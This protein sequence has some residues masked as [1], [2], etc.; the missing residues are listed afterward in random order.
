MWRNKP[1]IETL[2]LDNLF[3]NL[4]DYKSEVKGTS[5]STTNSHNVAF[6]SS[7]STSD[8]T[9]AVNIAQGVNT[10]S[11]QGDADSSTTVENLSDDVIY[12]FFASQPIIPQLDNE[13]LLQIH[14]DDL[15][16]MDLR[17]NIAMLTMKARRFL[18][19]TGRKLDMAN[20]E[21][22]RF[23]KSKVECFNCHKRG[24]FARECRAPRNQ[25]S[26]NK[27]PTR[28]TLPVEET[29]SNA[30]VSQCDSFGYDWCDQVEEDLKNKGVIDSGCSR[31]MTGNKSYLT[32]Y[33][34]I[35]RG[36][37]A[38]GDFLLIDE[39]HVLLKVPRKDNMYSVDLK[40]VVPQGGTK[41][42]TDAREKKDAEDPGN[43][44]GNPTEGESI[45]LPNDPNMPELEDIVYSDDDE[46]DVGQRLKR[47]SMF[48]N[49]QDLKIQTSLTEFTSRK[50]SLWFDIKALELEGLRWYSD[51]TG[52]QVKQ[53]EDEIFISQDKYVTEI[54][55]K[56][57]FSDIKTAS[58]PMETHKPLLKDA[59][60][61]DINEH[62]YRS[63][64]GLLMY[65][66][67][68]RPDIMFVVCV[69]ARFQVNP[70]VSQ[71]HAVKRIF[72]Y[73]KGQPKLGLW[74][75]KDSPFDLVAYTDW[76]M[77][78][79]T[80]DRKSTTEGC[81]FLGCR[82]IS[83]QCKKQ[84]VVC[85]IPHK[86]LIYVASFMCVAKWL[87]IQIN[88]GLWKGIRVNAGDSKLMLLGINLLLLEKVNAAR[89]NLLL[90]VL[91]ALVD[92]KKVIITETSVRRDLQLKDVE[93]IECLPNA[94]IFEQLALM[95]YEK[96]SQK[97]TFY[98]AFFSPQWKFLIHTILQC[99]SA[100]STAWNEFSNTM[101]SAIICLATTENSNSSMYIFWQS[102]VKIGS[103]ML[104]DPHHTPI[105]QPSTSQPQK[106]QSRRKQI[107]D[108][109]I[110][111]SSGP[112]EPIADE[113]ANEENVPTQSNDPPLSRVNTIRSG[114]D[115]LT[116]KELMDLCTKLSDSVLDLETTK[117]AQAKEITSLKK[118][119]KNLERKRKSKTPG[120]KRLFK[121]GRS[122]QVV[123]SEDEG[124]GDQG[125]HLRG[126]VVSFEELGVRLPR[127][128][129][130][131]V[132]SASG[133]SSLQ[134]GDGGACV[135]AR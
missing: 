97:H 116:L 125:Y 104:H 78:G 133:G 130:E 115:R 113:T 48:V 68:S 32:D 8:A 103:T 98:K 128:D 82:L 134:E 2:S 21:R 49:H 66:T 55:K 51:S 24:H 37:V 56:F 28:R 96:P 101:A 59:D 23:D 57:G 69:C 110:P 92:R 25:D 76:T 3:N 50:G 71:L 74:Y 90:L 80:L 89:H 1:E 99:L 107:K 64:I 27:E 54:L 77:Q 108:T 39:R 41:D 118:R 13:Y 127:G 123:S 129:E 117:T 38:F 94:D 9:R 46:C 121:I 135:A 35:N 29:T 91:Q 102:L 60:G 122:V 126:H 93:G 65:L 43:E 124:L 75:P 18:K 44:S 63:M 12:S 70:K 45:E 114:E 95:R 14:P 4:K 26:R 34:E 42:V 6:L 16:E 5:S 53:K 36:F 106:K 15:E 84:T 73:L 40:N 10:A 83:W 86:K 61:E 105:I 81:Q 87:G 58:T 131:G 47:K 109:E 22:I 17:W 88:C 119:V 67:S 112:T 111:Q 33:E 120:M 11:T 79:K 19:N 72:R 62:I 85:Y 30:L 31:H 52:L 7:S 20:K 100:K 132:W